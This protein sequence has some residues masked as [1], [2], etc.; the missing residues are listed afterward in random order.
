M[1]FEGFESAI[2]VTIAID[3]PLLLLLKLSAIATIAPLSV[4]L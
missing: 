1:T 4:R 2:E 3:S